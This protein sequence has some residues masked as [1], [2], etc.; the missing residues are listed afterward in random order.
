MRT[1][2]LGYPR[3]GSQH[4]LK[5]EQSTWN[6]VHGRKGEGY[7]QCYVSCTLLLS[8]CSWLACLLLTAGFPFAPSSLLYR[9]I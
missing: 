3:I 1:H 2:N 5:K 6:K 7:K 4:E 8:F 9:E